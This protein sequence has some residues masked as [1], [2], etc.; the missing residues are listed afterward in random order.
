LI[1]RRKASF[2]LNLGG[3]ML[4]NAFRYIFIVIS[5]A[6]IL[7]CGGPKEYKVWSDGYLNKGMMVTDAKGDLQKDGK[8]VR[9]TQDNRVVS[10][11][12]YKIGKREGVTVNY[13][14]NGNKL[15]ETQ[16]ANDKKNGVYKEW[17]AKQELIKEATYKDDKLNGAYLEKREDGEHKGFYKDEKK[18]GEWSHTW[19]SGAKSIATYKEGKMDGPWKKLFKDGTVAEIGQYKNDKPVGEWKSW[20][21]PKQ[22]WWTG[23]YD[24]E[25]KFHGKKTIWYEDGKTQEICVYEHGKEMELKE[26]DKNGKLTNDAKRR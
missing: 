3:V 15:N 19:P 12:E 5:L 7:G 18:D 23:S 21:T 10:E 1:K 13:R 6:I 17:N 9:M 25:G 14:P 24:D 2:A 8:W 26:W 16:Y 4:R 11:T 22:M 20:F